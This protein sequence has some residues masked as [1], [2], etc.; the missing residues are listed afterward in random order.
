MGSSRAAPLEAGRAHHL[1]HHVDEHAAQS[2]RRKGSTHMFRNRRLLALAVAGALV[3]AAC[4]GDDD[5]SS[6][7]APERP[8]AEDLPTEVDR[9][10][11]FAGTDTFCEPAEAEPEEAPEATDP[12][13]TEEEIVVTHVRVTLEDLT[14]LGFAVPVGDTADQVER[15][16]EMINERCGGIHG[17][18]LRIELTEYPVIPRDDPTLVAQEQCIRVTEDHEAAIAL[19]PSGQGGLL[20]RCL[21]SQNDTIFLTTVQLPEDEIEA[22]GDRLYSMSVSSTE[23]LE[24]ALRALHEAGALEGR[25][26]GVVYQDNTNQPQI[27]EQGFLRTAEELGIDVVR[28][29]RLQC[30]ANTCPG[31]IRES[32]TGMLADGVD[33]I[34]PL[35][36]VLNA[37]S[38]MAEL[39]TQGATPGD[40]TFYNTAFNAQDSDI[41]TSKIPEFG[42]EPA[43]ALYD[44]ATIFSGAPT[45]VFRQ[46]GYEPEAFMEMC[47]RE[48]QEAG[49]EA[50][51]VLD[52]ETSTPYLM[53]GT[54]CSMMRVIARA[55]EA[56]GPNPTRDDLASAFENLGA[57]DM[58]FDVPA[59]FAPGKYTAPNAIYEMR[60]HFPCEA[61]LPTSADTCVVAE[62][63][64]REIDRD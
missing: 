16:A 4:G 1:P 11:R 23:A 38:Y 13:I 22:A 9:E 35:L 54:V 42:G 47:N 64:A 60:F 30:E 52:P 12:G 26:V 49:G 33:V 50:F 3:V 10:S 56:A 43:G 53:V 48:Y 57:I 59:S 46:P 5:S 2:G 44:G 39:A 41:V 51:D 37:P 62:D 55:V 20:T 58:N 29:D 27:V 19:S 21:T 14:D 40:I 45:G 28:A 15:F 17:R 7:A 31:G 36:S 25:A 34:F 61:P 18:S 24:H 63:E 6:S 8:A 32:V